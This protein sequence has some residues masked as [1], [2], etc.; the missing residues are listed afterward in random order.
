M[1]KYFFLFLFFLGVHLQTIGSNPALTIDHIEPSFWWAGMKNRDLQIMV[2]AKDIAYLRPKIN[3]PGIRLVNVIQTSNRNYLFLNLEIQPTVK[4]QTFS[5]DFLKDEKVVFSHPYTLKERK[6]NSAARQGFSTADVLYLITPDR[7]ANGDPSN[8]NHPDMR[9]KS[10]R[11]FKGGRHGGDI[12]GIIK[13]LDYIKSTGFSAIWLNPVLENNQ[14]EYSYHGY[15]ITDFYKVDPRFGS[16]DSYLDLVKNCHEKGLKVIMD[17]I[18]NHCGSFHWWMNDLPDTDWINF[19]NKFVNTTHQKPVIQDVHVSE[20][21]KKMFTD[22]WFVETMPDLNQK[23]KLLATYLIQ[24]AIWWIE[25]ADIDGIRMDTY[26]YP[27]KDFMSDWTCAVMAEYPGFNIVGEEWSENPAIVAHWLKGK[28]NPNGY[29]SCLPGAMDFPIQ[30]ALRKS[31]TNNNWYPL[32]ETLT[33]DFLY[34]DANSLVVFPDNHDMSRLYSQVN[35]NLELFNLGLTYM[36]T[37]RG[38]PQIYYGTEILMSNPG[39]D[40]H[41]V[42]RSDFPGGWQGDLKNGFSNIG[43]LSKQIETK[44]HIQKLLKWRE[45]KGV[46]H[47][48]KMMHFVPEN[49]I[50]VYFRYD[51]DEK[52]MVVLSLNKKDVSLDL[53]RFREML[54]SSF[55]ATEII[56]G[57]N[58]DLSDSLIVPAYKSLILSLK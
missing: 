52:V 33:M 49:N 44:N 20:Y 35:E 8:D 56:S 24:N 55:K 42:I 22:G 31:L 40:D 27:D 18:V 30:G 13:N 29:T 10:N 54:P 36:L 43:L 5:I 47:H 17:M 3:S 51:N 32:Y 58:M 37:T 16:N 34:P 11:S 46:I 28:V 57:T 41:G 2:H 39:T 25:Y 53:K 14:T 23:N 9:E 7:F 19:D 1:K 15:S 26:P 12:A 6:V 38:T 21:D 48:G 45:K 4:P 50:Y